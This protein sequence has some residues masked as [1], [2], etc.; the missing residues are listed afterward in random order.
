MSG[1]DISIHGKVEIEEG[2]IAGVYQ[3][4]LHPKRDDRGFFMRTY[5]KTIFEK[6]DLK[7][8]WIQENHSLSIH[9]N[10]LRGLHF[11]MPPFTETKLIRCIKGKIWD[12]FADLRCGSSTFGQWDAVELSEDESKMLL[13]P[14]GLAHGFLTLQDN[15]EVL[16]K[17]DNPYTPEFESGIIWNDPDLDIAWPLTEEPIL[18]DK[19]ARNQSF[20]AFIKEK[21][22]V[23]V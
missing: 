22:C 6:F 19:D 21:R 8:T 5:D 11:Q 1:S 23:K 4:H 10:T 15:C 12:V 3:I 16:Y 7:K 9:T 2:K 14:K 17:V 20:K 13:I 18:S